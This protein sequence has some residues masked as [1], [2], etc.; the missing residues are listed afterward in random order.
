MIRILKLG[1]TPMEEIL[2]RNVPAVDVGGAVSNILEDVR[3]HG[4]EALFR[5]AEQFD[6]VRLAV[7]EVTEDEISEAFA[8]VEPAFL[9]VLRGAAANIRAFHEKQVRSGFMMSSHSGT[10]LGQRVIPVEK[11]GLYVPG[12]TAAYPS[13]VLMD[14]IPAQIAGCRE[15]CIATPPNRQGKISPAVLAAAKIAGVTRIFKMGGARQLQ[16]WLS[17]RRV[18]RRWIKLSDPATLMWRRQNVRFSEWSASI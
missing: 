6:R 10:L 18:C 1:E 9:E 4:D 15:I 5:Y 2:S 11:V 17:V 13:T 8:A 12:G 7:L 14:A 3:K 16:H